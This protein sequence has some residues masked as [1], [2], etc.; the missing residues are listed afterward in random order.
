MKKSIQSWGSG[1]AP[2]KRNERKKK[3]KRIF[4]YDGEMKFLESFW[5]LK[6]KILSIDEFRD[7][8]T[9]TLVKTEQINAFILDYFIEELR[10]KV[11]IEE[12]RNLTMNKAKQVNEIKNEISELNDKIREL[13]YSLKD[14]PQPGFFDNVGDSCS[15][16]SSRRISSC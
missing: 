12:M 8:A 6:C 11:E 13:E 2:K 9:E 10:I 16:G 3:L 1:D 14:E 7:L 5:E 4:N 15:K